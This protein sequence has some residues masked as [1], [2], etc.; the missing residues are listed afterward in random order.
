L[1][2]AFFIKYLPL[3]LIDLRTIVN[4]RHCLLGIDFA[5]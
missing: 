5:V 4:S 2:Y 3:Y 1:A